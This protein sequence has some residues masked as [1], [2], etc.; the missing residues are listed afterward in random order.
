M[1]KHPN[2]PHNPLKAAAER[3]MKSRGM[4]KMF[5]EKKLKVKKK[6]AKQAIG[7]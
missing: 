7:S 2:S 4:R 6:R 3:V 5:Q 1:P